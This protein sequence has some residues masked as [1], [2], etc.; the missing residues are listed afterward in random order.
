MAVA[1]GTV[2]SVVSD[3]PN[4]PPGALSRIPFEQLAGNRIIVD[5]GNAV[6]ALYGDV[7]NNGV[8]VKVGEKVKKG[9]VIGRLGNSGSTTEP[10]LHFQLMRGRSR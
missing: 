8:A 7:K 4:V 3:Q 10:H 2:V 5:I 9:Q 6:F 1:D